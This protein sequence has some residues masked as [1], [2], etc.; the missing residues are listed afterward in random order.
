[1]LVFYYVIVTITLFTKAMYMGLSQ[2]KHRNELKHLFYYP[3]EEYIYI[4]LEEQKNKYIWTIENTGIHIDE[5]ENEL[6]FKEFYRHDKSRNQKNRG[7]GLGLAIV[8]TILEAHKLNYNFENTEK[9]MKFT[10]EFP[11][12][13]E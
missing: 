10:I 2:E 6:L 8:K 9:G 13:G 11:K 1:M 12:I 5:I 4:Q 7:N 3:D